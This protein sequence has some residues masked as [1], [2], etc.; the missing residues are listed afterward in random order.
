MPLACRYM[1]VDEER[2]ITVS[3]FG[4]SIGHSLG[5]N[6]GYDDG[7]TLSLVWRALAKAFKV[8]PTAEE[9]RKAMQTEAVEAPFK[10]TPRAAGDRT[11]ASVREEKQLHE[12]KAAAAKEQGAAAFAGS[13]TCTCPPGEGFG[14][15]F[16][17]PKSDVL[18]PPTEGGACPHKV[19][20]AL[21]PA[22]DWCPA[23]AYVFAR[24]RAP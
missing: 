21:P 7:Y 3:T 6:K 15:C 20:N 14:K 8:K 17:I 22:Y 2:N 13:C 9:V 16:N 12:R 5:C 11:R 1:W 18:L 23:I 10:G 19:T 4:Q 24:A